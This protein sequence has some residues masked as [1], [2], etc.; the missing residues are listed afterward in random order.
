MKKYILAITTCTLALPLFAFNFNAENLEIDTN[1]KAKL[2]AII[3]KEISSIKQ[4]AAVTN[5][6][7]NEI[8]T[9]IQEKLEITLKNIERNSHFRKKFPNGKF[10]REQKIQKQKF[11]N[12]KEWNI[13]SKI[14]DYIVN[15]FDVRKIKNVEVICSYINKTGIDVH[16]SYETDK[17]EVSY[18]YTEN[19][20]APSISHTITK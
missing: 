11:E 14:Y 6:T 17:I 15:N 12:M 1:I 8:L 3:T 16:F 13:P 9:A 5:N 10:V 7:D 2:N 4:N 18:I 20:W 19:Y